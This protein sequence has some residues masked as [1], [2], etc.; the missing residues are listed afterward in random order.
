MSRTRY[1][2]RWWMRRAMEDGPQARARRHAE[3][4]HARA[5]IERD[6]D[7]DQDTP[8]RSRI[9]PHQPQDTPTDR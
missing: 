7:D 1:S 8:T 2:A 6:D 9:A 3:Q 4:E 5:V